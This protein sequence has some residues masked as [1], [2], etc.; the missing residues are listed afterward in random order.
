MLIR[1]ELTYDASPEDV[2]DMLSSPAFRE[3]VCEAMDTASHDV[4]VDRTE[5]G[6]SVRIDMLQRT[7]GLPGFATKIVGDKTRI[8]QTEKWVAAQSAEL[9][10]EIPGKPGHIRGSI[11]LRGDGSRTVEAFLGEAK[12]NLPLVG[13]KVEGLIKRLFIRGMDTEQRAGA[14]WLAGERG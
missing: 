8:I 7:Q 12:I 3:R 5:D 1:H 10:V 2:Y 9:A 14:A 6:M 11:T 13:G 4:S